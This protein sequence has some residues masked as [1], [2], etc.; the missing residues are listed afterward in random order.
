MRVRAHSLGEG[1]E[2]RARQRR[3]RIII[4]LGQVLLSHS[5]WE[6]RSDAATADVANFFAKLK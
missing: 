6:L 1:K 3:R 2:R 4:Q 5:Q